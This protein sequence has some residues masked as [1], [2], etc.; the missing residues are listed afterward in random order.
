MKKFLATLGIISAI[1][2]VG[3]ASV[4][5][6]TVKA[7]LSEGWKVPL[8]NSD[9]TLQFWGSSLWFGVSGQTTVSVANSNGGFA[10]V[11]VHGNNSGNI[12]QTDVKSGGKIQTERC[13]ANGSYAT[14]VDYKWERTGTGAF[15]G[16]RTYVHNGGNN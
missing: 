10:Y 2:T 9:V 15:K 8:Q 5:A 3:I 11:Y 13:Y 1:A 16:S 6:D 14:S 4:S 7:D 12:K